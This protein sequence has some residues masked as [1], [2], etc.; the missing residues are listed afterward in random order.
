[1]RQ[2]VAVIV[3]SDACTLARPISLDLRESEI[4]EIKEVKENK[5]REYHDSDPDCVRPRAALWAE[6]YLQSRMIKSFCGKP[7]RS[8]KRRLFVMPKHLTGKVSVSC[9]LCHNIR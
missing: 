6:A 9:A 7:E 3:T 4:E 2:E 5:A 1:M 8:R